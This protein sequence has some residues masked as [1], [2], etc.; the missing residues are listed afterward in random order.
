MLFISFFVYSIAF[1]WFL[2]FLSRAKDEAKPLPMSVAQQGAYALWLPDGMVEPELSPAPT[3]VFSTPEM[4]NYDGFILR[5]AGGVDVPSNLP[6]R[7]FATQSD[8]LSVMPRPRGGAMDLFYERMRRDFA[9]AAWVNDPKNAASFVDHRCVWFRGC[10][11]T[12]PSGEICE[13]FRIGRARKAHGLETRLYVGFEMGDE[14]REIRAPAMNWTQI[15]SELHDWYLPQP[16]LRR[17]LP[18]FSIMMW[19]GS[20]AGLVWPEVRDAAILSLTLG[21]AQRLCAALYDGFSIK[22]VLIAPFA[23]PWFWVKASRYAVVQRLAVQPDLSAWQSSDEIAPSGRQRWRWLDESLFIFSARR[24][25]GSAKVMKLLYDHEPQGFTHRGLALDR[26]IHQLPAARAVRFRRYS[27]QEALSTL[28]GVEVLMSLPSGTAQ[29]LKRHH[30]TDIYLVDMDPEA[31][32]VAK[33]NLPNA[34]VIEGSFA[35]LKFERHCDA[36]V[37]CGL[38]EY[39]GDNEVVAQLRQIRGLVGTQGTLITSTTQGNTQVPMMSEHIGW[40]T[41]TRTMDEYRALMELAGFRIVEQWSDPNQ[42]QVVYIAI[43]VE[44]F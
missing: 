7:C 18:S 2:I 10:D 9:Q 12:L 14:A 8:F 29:D 38:A 5:L 6:S 36:F 11:A 43:G 19:C 31:L 27:V 35:D 33:S 1:I 4:P 28:Q 16:L 3:A 42:I 44:T 30:A 21:L 23:E 40:R 26:W 25:G 41:R 20:L 32:S 13:V 24:L 39:L 17:F 34:Q 15:Q 22:L 37:Y